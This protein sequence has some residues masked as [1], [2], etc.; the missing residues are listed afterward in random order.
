MPHVQTVT[1]PIEAT[2]LVAMIDWVFWVANDGV[3]WVS[4]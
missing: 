3:S 2:A 4:S 1:G